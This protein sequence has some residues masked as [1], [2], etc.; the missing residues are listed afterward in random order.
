MKLL[1]VDFSNL[2]YRNIFSHPT[3]TFAGRF[4]GGSFGT[5]ISLVKL[6]QLY[7]QHKVVICRDTPPYYREQFFKGYKG[8][9]KRHDNATLSMVADSV[10]QAN[11]ILS[12]IGLPSV[13]IP[14][15][16]ADDIIGILCKDNECVIASGDSDL[17]QLLSDNVFMQLPKRTYTL[18]D[19]GKEFN[20]KPAQWPFVLAMAGSHNGVKGFPKVGVKTAVTYL[21]KGIDFIFEKFGES[22][23]SSL[24]R[25]LDLATIPFPHIKQAVNVNI[26][27]TSAYNERALLRVLSLYGITFTKAMATAF[28]N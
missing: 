24:E 7:P 10:H 19:F 20:I 11:Q 12:A 22:G 14:G 13:S 18:D 16:E 2:L 6:R 15:L 27:V 23:I 9:R 17:Y 28:E 8:D 4:T 1:L 26:E 3:L 5:L 25:D 21:N